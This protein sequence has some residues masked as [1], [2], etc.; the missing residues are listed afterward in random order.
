MLKTQTVRSLAELAGV[1]GLRWVIETGLTPVS[2]SVERLGSGYLM[3]RHAVLLVGAI[4]WFG[5]RRSH[6]RPGPHEGAAVA[7]SGGQ[8]RPLLGPPEGLVLDAR[9]HGG[10][11]VCVGIDSR[12]LMP[13][14]VVDR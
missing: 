5:P 13:P 8:G 7:R 10:R 1:A 12:R 14:L 3:W 2:W 6:F 11:L 4:L 9:E